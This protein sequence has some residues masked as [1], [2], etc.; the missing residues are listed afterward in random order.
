MCGRFAL[1]DET[2]VARHILVDKWNWHWPCPRFNV[3]PTTRVPIVLKAEDLKTALKNAPGVQFCPS[4]KCISKHS[5][6]TVRRPRQ[7][8][9]VFHPW[10]S[11]ERPRRAYRDGSLF[12]ADSHILLRPNVTAHRRETR[13]GS[14][15]RVSPYVRYLSLS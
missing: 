10:R 2:V 5:A 4:S 6:R 3:A 9:L 12:Q 7:H 1:P 13:R 8:F 14:R 11:A 15:V